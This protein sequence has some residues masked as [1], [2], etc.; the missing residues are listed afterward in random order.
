MEILFFLNCFSKHT[1][2]LFSAV[3][4]R[5]VSSGL[6]GLGLGDSH[7]LKKDWINGSR[8]CPFYRNQRKQI[9]NEKR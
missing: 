6:L 8:F 4:L 3:G 1:F 5:M 7:E 2:L 9:L